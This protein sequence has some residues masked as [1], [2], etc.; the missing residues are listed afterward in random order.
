MHTPVSWSRRGVLSLLGGG[1]FGGSGSA[2]GAHTT[3]RPRV[4]AAPSPAPGSTLLARS[5]VVVADLPRALA[6]Y[7]DGLGL[8]VVNEIKGDTAAVGDS[9]PFG[10][11]AG[12]FHLVMLGSGASSAVVAVLQFAD[13]ALA[14]ATPTARLG[15]GDVVFV[16]DTQEI[17]A[18]FARVKASGARIYRALYDRPVRNG[19]RTRSFTCY[20]P[21][22]TFLE[23]AGPAHD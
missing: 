15:I 1:A 11:P 4:Q 6:F 9:F 22:G 5:T 17:E 8:H 14:P 23:V 10:L 19:M 20:D 2:S 21:D 7:R 13:P 16:F 18:V 12:R 3:S